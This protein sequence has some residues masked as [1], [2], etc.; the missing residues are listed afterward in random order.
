[1]KNPPSL[2]TRPEMCGPAGSGM[3]VTVRRLLRVNTPSC[4][5]SFKSATRPSTLKC[6][7]LDWN[8]NVRQIPGTDDQRARIWVGRRC[9]THL[10]SSWKHLRDLKG[11]IRID[12][13]RDGKGNRSP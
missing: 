1:M 5:S 6:A 4:R 11:A 12:R 8:L 10:I 2:A 7:E 3:R 13:C 9:Q